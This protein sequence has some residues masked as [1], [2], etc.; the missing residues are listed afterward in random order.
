MYPRSERRPWGRRQRKGCRSAHPT[1]Y[2]S[3]ALFLTP[4][5]S[6]L[7][8]PGCRG[9]RGGGVQVAR[10][11]RQGLEFWSRARTGSE[12][13]WILDRASQIGTRHARRLAGSGKS[14]W[15]TGARRPLRG[16]HQVVSRRDREFPNARDSLR[17][18]M[19]RDVD[20]MLA[21][22]RNLSA[23]TRAHAALREM[24]ECWVMG[25]AAGVAA[26]LAVSGGHRLRD[27]SV[28]ELQRRLLERGAI[29]E[30][31]RWGPRA[32]SGRRR[33]AA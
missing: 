23:D 3:V 5:M 17:R 26:V 19:P 31:A 29:I 13:A 2:D 15:T 10:H 22:G 28:P 6:G 9:S 8:R 11:A 16:H 30:S 24:P 12:R 21:A 33:H 20:G 32:R 4:K 18:L 25:E 14:R 1:P 27:V 7:L